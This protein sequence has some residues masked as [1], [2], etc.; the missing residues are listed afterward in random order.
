MSFG[1]IQE[2]QNFRLPEVAQKSIL[3]SSQGL[4]PCHP[5]SRP[6]SVFLMLVFVFA[7]V[8]GLRL[9][10]WSFVFGQIFSLR[11][12]LRVRLDYVRPS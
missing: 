12:R 8:F 6:V 2:T 3:H 1:S 9:L 5:E 11:L 10:V 7:V 4:Y